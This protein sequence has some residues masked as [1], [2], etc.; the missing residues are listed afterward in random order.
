MRLPPNLKYFLLFIFA[1][2]IIVLATIYLPRYIP[3]IGK[4]LGAVLIYGML[5]L[6]VFVFIKPFLTFLY[7]RTDGILAVYKDQS[8]NG[9]HVFGYHINPSGESGGSSTRDIQHYFILYEKGKIFY[10]SIYTHS[11]EPLSGRSGWEGYISFEES[12]LTSPMY[13]KSMKKLSARSGIN[14]QLGE[15][16]KE[17]ADDHFNIHTTTMNIE[18]KKFENAVDEGMR[19]TCTEKSSGSVLWT[20]KI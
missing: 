11:M 12:V 10:R 8:G 9:F 16:I 14:L 1:I 3:N 7:A 17:S 2:G 15:S 18:L 5:G 13:E 19:L 6:C 20:K 4:I